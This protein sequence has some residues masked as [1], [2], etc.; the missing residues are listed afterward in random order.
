MKVGLTQGRIEFDP[1]EPDLDQVCFRYGAFLKSREIQ[2][3]QLLKGLLVLP[4]DSDA[5]PCQHR[6]KV[7]P[8][9]FCHALP[10][11]IREF[12]FGGRDRRRSH[13][14]ARS[15]LAPEFDRLGIR[16]AEFVQARRFRRS[17]HPQIFC[18]DRQSGIR[19][20]A[21]RDLIGLRPFQA[22]SGRLQLQISFDIHADD[23][24]EIERRRVLRIARSGDQRHQQR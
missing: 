16:R 5:A 22:V 24:L 12:C 2:L 8:P 21:C 6:F 14:F 20:Q 10:H 19:P 18:R 4:G 23:A 13:T 1:L 3:Y 7:K 15:A 11:R 9:D 17:R